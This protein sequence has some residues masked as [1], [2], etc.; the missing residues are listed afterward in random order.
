MSQAQSA[1]KTRRA[2]EK[3][4]ARAILY[5]CP[6]SRCLIVNAVL[7]NG[8]RYELD[9][10]KEYIDFRKRRR[11]PCTC[12]ATRAE[13][14]AGDIVPDPQF[15]Q[16]VEEFVKEVTAKAAKDSSREQWADLLDD[17]TRWT[18]AKAG[19]GAA[20]TQPYSYS[21]PEP[22][23]TRRTSIHSPTSPVYSDT[24]DVM[25]ED[26][27]TPTTP[28][29]TG[30]QQDSAIVLEDSDD[31]QP[32]E[33]NGA[34]GPSGP[35]GSGTSV[36]SGDADSPLIGCIVSYTHDP[37]RRAGIVSEKRGTAITL[38]TFTGAIVQAQEEHIQP[39]P[40]RIYDTVKILSGPLAHKTGVLRATT[41]TGE[42]VV[43]LA[44]GIGHD[45]GRNQFAPLAACA[46]ILGSN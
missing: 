5:T 33:S 30:A 10:L 44:D 13:L 3:Y 39:A 28:V 31:E 29:Y 19:A 2:V 6:L 14:R 43:V 26:D 16:I 45:S 17:C 40:V 20:P 24:D 41:D 1:E 15:A 42:G 36:A 7:V 21:E 11:L 12:P 8:Q 27:N 35:S 4:T 9:D 22:I 46:P 37:E 32:R 38:S 23:V 34:S 18:Q 25:P